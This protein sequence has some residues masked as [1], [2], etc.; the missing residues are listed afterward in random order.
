MRTSETLVAGCTDSEL[1][2]AYCTDCECFEQSPWTPE[3][4]WCTADMG[5]AEK[6]DTVWDMQ[7][8]DFIP[9]EGYRA[10]M[11]EAE[12]EFKVDAAAFECDVRRGK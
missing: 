10:R 8:A 9:S 4:G 11:Y 2:V 12:R 3:K 1:K 5:W 7:C 6:L